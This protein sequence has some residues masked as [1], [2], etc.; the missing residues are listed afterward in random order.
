MPTLEPYKG[1]NFLWKYVPSLALSLVFMVLFTVL[2]LLHTWKMWKSRLWFCAPFVFGGL[3]EY[4]SPRSHSEAPP[5]TLTYPVEVLG[6]IFRAACYERTSNLITYL[7]QSIFLVLPPVFFAASMYMVYTRLVRTL[8]REDCS[9]ITARWSTRLFLIADIVALNIQGNGGGLTASQNSNTADIGRWIL[10]A[11]LLVHVLIF[12]GFLTICV[13]FHRRFKI[14]LKITDTT[15]DVPWRQSLVMLYITSALVTARNIFRTAEYVMGE[16]EYLFTN[17]WC[18]YTFDSAPM[19]L[20]MVAFFIWYPDQLRGG[21]ENRLELD[22][23]GGS[24]E[25]SLSRAET[26]RESATL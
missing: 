12:I 10:V 21:K 16:D 26:G 17:E 20:V 5:L 8:Q 15:T 19:L 24:V 13:N 3:C 7:L 25:D 22:S 11:G 14:Y 4:S 23:R 6:F 1:D 9:L 18:I 2:T